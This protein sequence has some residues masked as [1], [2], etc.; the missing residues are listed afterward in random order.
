MPGD[1][2]YPHQEEEGMK[3]FSI[4]CS[5]IDGHQESSGNFRSNKPMAYERIGAD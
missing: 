3:I 2:G 5:E 1:L 4:E